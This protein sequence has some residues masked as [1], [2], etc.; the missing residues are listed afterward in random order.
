[1]VRRPAPPGG[2]WPPDRW[3]LLDGTI[4]L[5]HT[6]SLLSVRKDVE[7]YDSDQTEIR[8][9]NTAGNRYGSRLVR[10]PGAGPKT[11]RQG[12]QEGGRGRN[13][14]ARCGEGGGWRPEHDHDNHLPQG[15]ARRGPDVIGPE[16]GR[17]VHRRWTAQ[18]K[19]Q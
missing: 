18:G 1:P 14:S 3:V 13:G 8:Y 11:G 7:E 17:G 5:H 12:R 16:I 2:A 15:P 9:R 19:E 4:S 10:A 6:G